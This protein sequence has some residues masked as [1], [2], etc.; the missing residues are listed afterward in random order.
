M[1]TGDSP[2][3]PYFCSVHVYA[4]SCFSTLCIAVTAANEGRTVILVTITGPT[5]V[6]PAARRGTTPYGAASFADGQSGRRTM[7]VH[8]IYEDQSVS[9]TVTGVP[10]EWRC[11][12]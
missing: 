11:S 10:M 2:F 5:F 8:I 4:S 9:I 6:K 12:Y 3:Q 7:L 1:L